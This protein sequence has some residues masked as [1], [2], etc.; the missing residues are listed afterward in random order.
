MKRI[1]VFASLLFVAALLLVAAANPKTTGD[2]S[3]INP[4]W[5]GQQAHTVFNAINTSPAGPAAKG[6][7][8]YEDPNI[9]YSMDVQFLRVDPSTNTAWF[10]GQVTAVQDQ[11]GVGCCKVGNWILYQVQDKGEPGIGTDLIWGQDLGTTNA[12]AVREAVWN[13][14]TP[15][16]GPFTLNGGNIQVH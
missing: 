4:Y 12:D 13:K 11:G 7:L 1:F 2:A 15:G 3:W 8:L 14:Q 9:S 6:S 5:G 16:G 10:A